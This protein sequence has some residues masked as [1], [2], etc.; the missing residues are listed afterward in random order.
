MGV[1][2]AVLVVAGSLAALVGF[3]L[4]VSG[5][6]LGWAH[7][8]QRD[9]AGYYASGTHRVESA[10]Y[11][12]T[13]E[14][15]DL[16]T[17][18]RDGDWFPFDELGTVRLDAVDPGGAPLFVGIGPS[19]A[20]DRYL[21]DVAHHQV[22]SMSVRPREVDYRARPGD[23]VPE[24]PGEQGFWAASATGETLRWEV[25]GGDWTV[26]VMNPDGTAGVDAEVSVGIRTDLLA[27]IA[28]ALAV[29]GLLGLGVAGAFLVLALRNAVVAAPPRS[30]A[31]PVAPVPGAYPARL[32]G[33]LD[34]PLSRWLWLVKFV[35]VLPHVVV[36]AFLW[37]ATV[38][39]TV[40]AGVAILFTGRYPRPLFDFNVG[41]MR[42]TWRVGFYAVGAFGTDRYPPFRLAPDPD[43]PAD[44]DVDYPERLSRG[45]V[46]VKWWLLALPHLVIVSIFSGGWSVGADDGWRVAG[47]GGLIAV[48]AIIGAAVLTFRGTYPRELFHFV[49]GLN[50]WCF[51]VLAY[52]ALLR[53]EYPPF[54]FDGGGSDPGARPVVPPPPPPPVPASPAPTAPLVAA[55]GDAG[56]GR[57]GPG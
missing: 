32:E 50:R 12:V 41:V 1:G 9:D 30:A 57:G 8:T 16:G 4:L 49:M 48:V 33:T 10:G 26:V 44:F 35:L 28:V 24:P 51:R 53:D 31:V 25:E 3:A 13:S 52:V 5:A 6:V 2:R 20:V 54:R 11:A 45:L 23:A 56:H 14:H 36:L 18:V 15:I 42:W 38:V 27:P 37:M 29:A 47:G 19:D 39:L 17:D 22:D 46:L 7:A 21:A 40:V 43:Y 34:E 55:G